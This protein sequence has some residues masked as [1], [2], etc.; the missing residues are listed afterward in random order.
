MVA[1]LRG[2]KFVCG[3]GDEGVRPT[4]G[5]ASAAYQALADVYRW[6]G[7]ASTDEYVTTIHEERAAIFARATS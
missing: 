2:V 5:T 3:D 6:L 7:F 4:L 1:Q